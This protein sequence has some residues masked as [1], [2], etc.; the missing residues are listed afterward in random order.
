MNCF[1]RYILNIAGK[2][3]VVSVPNDMTKEKMNKCLAACRAYL[4]QYVYVE[5]ILAECFM[6]KVEAGV[7]KK[8]CFKFETKKKWKDAWL[9][10]QCYYPLQYHQYAPWHLRGGDGKA[11]RAVARELNRCL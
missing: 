7:Q 4:C 9:V 5:I 1:R 8:K 10:F 2:T 11:L 3:K 6:Q